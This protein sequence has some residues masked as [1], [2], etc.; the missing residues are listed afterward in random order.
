MVI[1]TESSWSVIL[2]ILSCTL[3]IQSHNILSL[4]FQEKEIDTS[5]FN[6]PKIHKANMWQIWN[7]KPRLPFI[8]KLP[9]VTTPNIKD[10]QIFHSIEQHFPLLYT[11]SQ[12]LLLHNVAIGP[13]CMLSKSLCIK[14]CFCN[15]NSSLTL[16]NCVKL[17][18]PFCCCCQWCSCLHHKRVLERGAMAWEGCWRS[19]KVK[20]NKAL[21]F[22]KE[23]E[24]T[25]KGMDVM[26]KHPSLKA[27]IA[28]RGLGDPYKHQA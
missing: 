17:G 26:A 16:W 21:D 24:K 18:M 6:L 1:R 20:P 5:K 28:F 8:L 11:L 19:G 7:Q 4:R 10:S 12:K 15:C 22:R 2:Y 14:A 27:E 25:E 9:V 23:D 13:R 3:I